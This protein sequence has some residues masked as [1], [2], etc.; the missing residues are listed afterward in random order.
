MLLL[1]GS[2]LFSLVICEIALRIFADIPVPK[3]PPKTK[4][5]D[6]YQQYTPYG[7]RLWP[8]RTMSY[9]YPRE[10]P[11]ELTIVSNS[12][13]FRSRRELQEPDERFRILILGDSF[14]FGDGVEAEER[15][16]NVLE[17]MEPDWRVDNLGMTGYG[18][19]LMLRALEK[20]GLHPVP[21]IVIFTMYTDDFR[22][23]QPFYAGVGFKIP[24]FKLK[25]GKL[26]SVPYPKRNIWNRCYLYLTCLDLF[27]KKTN[28]VYDLNSA[29]LDRFLELARTH[30]FQ[31]VIIFLPGW[32]DTP[33][34]KKR[35]TWLQQYARMHQVPYLDVSEPI[36]RHKWDEVFIKNN[37]H[38]NPMGH[39]IVAE[40]LHRFL[41]NEISGKLAFKSTT[42]NAEN[43]F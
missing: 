2:I 14:V 12:I 3:Y 9:K 21:D 36:H 39:H 41:K 28:I 27:W 17:E 13:G 34:D 25:N 22:R 43:D 37:W 42:T 31:P 40:Q 11:R 6:L 33:T 20:V 23:V 10:N 19:G 15:F 5:P 29:I 30:H 8:S 1:I 26:V 18:P 38:F 16:S 24:R 4:R 32:S 35:R 7:Y